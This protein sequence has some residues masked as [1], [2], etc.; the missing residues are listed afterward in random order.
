M[1][2]HLTRMDYYPV[3]DSPIGEADTMQKMLHI[4][5]VAS[6][7]VGQAYVIITVDEGVAQKLMIIL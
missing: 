3:I 5:S 6:E 2:E 4:S 1:P 7:E